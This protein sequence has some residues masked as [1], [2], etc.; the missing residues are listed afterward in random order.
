MEYIIPFGIYKM[1]TRGKRY[2][3]ESLG[4]MICDHCNKNIEEGEFYFCFKKN[5]YCY[6]CYDELPHHV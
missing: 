5:H 2:G 4:N 3:N 6:A 1:R